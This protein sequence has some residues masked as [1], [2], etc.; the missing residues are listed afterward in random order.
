MAITVEVSKFKAKDAN[1]ANWNPRSLLPAK[2]F[3][4]AK[5]HLEKWTKS[6]EIKDQAGARSYGDSVESQEEGLAG[7]GIEA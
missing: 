7:G 3:P 6:L 2:D 5:H 1:S 4:R